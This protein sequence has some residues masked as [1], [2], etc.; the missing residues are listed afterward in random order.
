MCDQLIEFMTSIKC[1]C[2][3]QFSL[4]RQNEQKRPKEREHKLNPHF[5]E[6][7]RSSVTGC[8]TGPSLSSSSLMLCNA[9][10]GNRFADHASVILLE[11]VCA[12]KEVN[13]VLVF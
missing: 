12:K 10:Q 3:G 8:T 2:P 5:P 11:D 1:L 4:V 13:F 9:S 6:A 7:A